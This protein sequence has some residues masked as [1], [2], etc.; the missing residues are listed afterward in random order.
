MA[1]EDGKA[2]GDA[3]SN[4]SNLRI[5][6][7]S[8]RWGPSKGY[9]VEDFLFSFFRRVESPGRIVLH[10]AFSSIS[11]EFVFLFIWHSASLRRAAETTFEY[12]EKSHQSVEMNVNQSASLWQRSQ[13]K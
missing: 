6:R 4:Q 11:I 12:V 9:K 1:T 7:F 13:Y 3:K 5:R 8:S 2:Y 10:A